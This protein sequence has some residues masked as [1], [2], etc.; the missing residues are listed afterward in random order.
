MTQS[1]FPSR[2]A[3][4]PGWAAAAVL[5]LLALAMAYGVAVVQPELHPGSPAP[6][7][8][9]GQGGADMLLYNRVV[10][11]MRGGAHYYPAAADALR[12]GGF[13]LQPF[14]AFRLPTLATLLA[15]LPPLAARALLMGLALAVIALWSRRIAPVFP[16]PP[17]RAIGAALVLCG[18]IVAAQ[19]SLIVFHEIWAALL[20]ALSLGLR[21]GDRWRASVVA[22]L[23]AV[24]IRETAIAYVLA[25]AVLALFDRRPRE[26]IAWGAVIAVFALYLAWHAGQVAAVVHPG[27]P[28][29]PGWKALGGWPAFI[30]AMRLTTPLLQFPSWVTALLVPAALLGWAGWRTP[31]AW[32]CFATL[33]GYALMIMLFARPDNFYWGLLIAPLLLLGLMFAPA[34]LADL[35]RALRP[36]DSG[37]AARQ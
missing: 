8:A 11:G 36:L 30:S 14:L 35:L 12:A 4:W 27:D 23:C 6:Q 28:S 15:T 9:D 19:P 31:A 1:A 20:I 7:A 17:Q 13:P 25:M 34:A 29:S 32:R 22:G 5:V 16:R 10:V 33:S 21:T 26:A 37:T 3:N 2:F 18:V 24:L